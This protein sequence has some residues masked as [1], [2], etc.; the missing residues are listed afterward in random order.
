MRRW[1]IILIGVAVSFLLSLAAAELALRFMGFEPFNPDAIRRLYIGNIRVEPGG[2][3]L[4]ADE[5]LGFV[6][7]GRRLDVTF[8]DLRFTVT[9][10]DQHHRISA[11][12]QVQADNQSLERG[13]WI[14]GC[15]FT[16]GFGVNDEETFPYLLQESFPTYRVTNL[17][18]ESGNNVQGYLQCHQMMKAGPPPALVVLA[19]AGFHEIRNVSL[20]VRRKELAPLNPF[21]SDVWMPF[22]R[23]ASDGSIEVYRDRLRYREWPGQ[24]S[25]ALVDLIDNVYAGQQ[26]ENSNKSAITREVIQSIVELCRLRGSKFLLAG[27]WPDARDTLAW[28]QENGI[29]SIDISFDPVDVGFLTASKVDRHPG[30]KGHR[31]YADLLRPKMEQ[32]LR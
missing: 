17:G 10:D 30:P 7:A 8:A 20:R 22:A 13:I 28:C 29:E 25:W 5:I 31:H 2:K 4:E 11:P 6:N 12:P 26:L 9:H 24:R 32:L 27:I 15:S 1:R 3:L 14:S 21:M 23:L 18:I 16:H 19:F